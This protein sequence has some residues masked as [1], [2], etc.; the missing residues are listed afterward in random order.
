MTTLTNSQWLECY[1]RG[2]GIK[3]TLKFYYDKR[4]GWMVVIN[5]NYDIAQTIGNDI[6]WAIAF[7]A[8]GKLDFLKERLK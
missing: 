7:V 2:R 8:E 4:N 1:A 5:D 3:D 6:Y